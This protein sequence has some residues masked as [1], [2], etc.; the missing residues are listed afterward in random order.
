M[1]NY[2][3]PTSFTRPILDI[4]SSS[5][6]Q[7]IDSIVA[8]STYVTADANGDKILYEGT[9]LRASPID[10]LK[11]APAAG[12]TVIGVCAYRY[13]LRTGDQ[14]IAIV[15]GGRLNRTRLYHNGVFG[16]PA[17][18]STPETNLRNIGIFIDE[19]DV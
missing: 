8:D 13:N 7:V 9:T 16:E 3:A 15:K 6:G 4:F 12:N 2:G 10:S 18:S 14:P 11:A 19:H 5:V 17:A 1:P